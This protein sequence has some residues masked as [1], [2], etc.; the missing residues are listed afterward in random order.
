MRL[1][2]KKLIC[3]VFVAFVIFSLLFG[4]VGG[5]A[6]AAE[7][8]SGY[9]NVIEDLQKDKT[10][11][12]EDYPAINGDYS[13]QVIQIAEST[14]GELFVY[15]YQPAA[16]VKPLVATQINMSLTDKMGGVIDEDVELTDE[17]K[18]KLYDL[19]L[20]N[21]AGVFAKYKVTNF[22]I[23]SVTV[24][25]YNITSI[26]RAW[27]EGLDEF[28]GNDNTISEVSF[29]VGKLYTSTSENGQVSYSCEKR[30]VV[31]VTDKYVDF[32]R[33]KNGVS[34]LGIYLEDYTD[35]H[36]IAF[37]TDWNMSDLYDVTISF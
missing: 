21:T 19:T 27:V 11:N 32:L 14:A 36:I 9:S 8:V 26:Y 34:G 25:Y 22:K 12:V 4:G 6:Y 3:F 13:L 16:N 1:V 10:F 7:F 33:Y 31:T 35:S 37:S 24:R 30:E 23:S 18:P 2:H 17:D 29:P 28:T 20:I 15:V 5:K